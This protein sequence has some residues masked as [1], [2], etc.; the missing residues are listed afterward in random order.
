M[1]MR[2]ES[3]KDTP[4]T[5]IETELDRIRREAFE[6]EAKALKEAALQHFK[7]QTSASLEGLKSAVRDEMTAAVK[8]AMAEQGMKEALRKELTDQVGKVAAN[9]TKQI[10]ERIKEDVAKEVKGAESRLGERLATWANE[11]KKSLTKAYSSARADAGSVKEESDTLPKEDVAAQTAEGSVDYSKVQRVTDK[12]EKVPRWKEILSDE[13]VVTS[14]I[15]G[16]FLV[17]AFLLWKRLGPPTPTSI[18]S[19]DSS[20]APVAETAAPSPP[21]E[22]SVTAQRVR[23][24]WIKVVVAAED[25]LS[26]DSSL[27]RLYR[28]HPPN[29]QFACWFTD[30][31]QEELENLARAS[32]PD[33]VQEKLEGIFEPCFAA[34]PPLRD[35]MLAIFSAQATVAKAFS[36]YRNEWDGWC[37]IA[38]ET[39][40][41][42]NPNADGVYGDATRDSLNLFLTCTSHS[43]ELTI[44]AGSTTPQYLYVT[45]L[46]LRELQR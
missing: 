22:L 9:L 38:N 17:A 25:T 37:A 10:E 31:A 35:P 4:G 14:I 5:R 26:S 40:P 20:A 36:Q 42:T 32:S 28:A 16:L 2:E 39:S 45:Y 11:T 29:N 3:M 21:A 33:D 6:K 15:V 13:K 19:P 23:T 7:D 27:R 24:D 46:A 18:T 8:Q 43:A 1:A 12:P 34:Q 30:G 41:P 44:A